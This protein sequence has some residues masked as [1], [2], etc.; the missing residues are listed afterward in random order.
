MVTR[1]QSIFPWVKT[2]GYKRTEP[3]ALWRFVKSRR[4]GSLVAVDFNPRNLYEIQ[5][6][7]EP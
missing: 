3:T 2:H 1:E 5:K 4:L 7:K 6:M